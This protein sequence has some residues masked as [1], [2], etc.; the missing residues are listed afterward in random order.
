MNLK[1]DLE[2]LL[3]D[4]LEKLVLFI[5]S[6]FDNKVNE[7]LTNQEYQ[8][9][10]LEIKCPSCGLT[11]FKK[12]GHKNGTQ[13]YL[14][15]NCNKSFSITTNTILNHSRIKYWQLKEFIK[16]LLDIKPVSEISQ[17]VKMSK[18]QIY[19]L[20]IKLFKALENV[21]NSVKLKGIVQADEKYFR[22]SFK[23]TKH[24]K[25]PRK[26]RHSGSQD[27][28]VGIN[29]EL[30]C[31]VVAIDE[32]D[33]IIIE[34]VGN[35]PA[36]TEMLEKGLGGKI[37]KG[38]I[39]V[40][41]SKSSYIKFAKN[42]NLILKQIPDGEYNVE[43]IYNLSEVNELI[44]ELENYITY[45]KKEVSTKHLQQYCNFVKYK[46]ILKYTIEYLERNEKM[47]KDSIILCSNL[48]NRSI[49]NIELPFDIIGIFDS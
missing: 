39:L 24:E 28:K 31:V 47:Y 2:Q 6:L 15:K 44:L 42:N 41:D 12:N 25:M 19:Y 29:K 11:F 3:P 46:K 36:S 45:M 49:S 43:E 1:Y 14:C 7:R 16:C 8:K 21:Y 9:N 13:R 27:L 18:T 26:T 17:H 37:E 20:E 38:S 33:N 4:E 34:V 22:I 23:G 30:A 35:G 5:N 48:T 10:N 32:N 40:T